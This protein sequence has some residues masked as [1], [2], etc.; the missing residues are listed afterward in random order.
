M[1]ALK[2]RGKALLKM[3]SRVQEDRLKAEQKARE[4]QAKV[5]PNITLKISKY[6]D[7]PYLWL[8]S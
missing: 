7:S 6:G 2:K 3:M 4:A 8:L 1:Q 5:S